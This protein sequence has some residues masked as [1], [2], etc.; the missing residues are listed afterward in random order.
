MIWLIRTEVCTMQNNIVKKVI[1]ASAGTGKTYRLSLEYLNLLIKYKASGIHFSEIVV[2]TFTNKA[3]AEIKEKIFEHL[4][5]IAD[6]NKDSGL[7]LK[8]NLQELFNIKVS[9]D[10]LNYLKLVYQQIKINQDKV[11]I[12]TIDSFINYT[13]KSMLAP[14]CMNLD[15][16]EISLTGDAYHLDDLYNL[17]FES[18]TMKD[19]FLGI[20]KKKD[21]KTL[22]FF[23]NFIISILNNR[24]LFELALKQ[25]KN[26]IFPENLIELYYESL[27]KNVSE[28]WD[29]VAD[30]Y[31]DL[32]FNTFSDLILTDF[33]D[34]IRVFLNLEKIN[35]L[36]DITSIKNEFYNILSSENFLLKNYKILLKNNFKF[37]NSQKFMKNK[38]LSFMENLQ[39]KFLEL[40][41]ILIQWLYVMLV[42][43]E[44]KELLELAEKIFSKYDE[45]KI[46]HKMLSHSDITFYTF[47]H[48]YDE[49][50]S[51]IDKQFNSVQNIF[52]EFLTYRIR[53]LLVDEFQDTSIMQYKILSP[54]ITELISGSTAKDYGGYIVVGDEKQ[55]IYGWRGGERELFRVLEQGLNPENLDV[56]YRS[57]KSI[58][59]FVNSVFRAENLKTFL[60]GNNADWECPLI[61]V[62][63]K[64]DDGFVKTIFFNSSNHDEDVY[65]VIA[66]KI[67]HPLAVTGRINTDNTVLLAY[68]N[69]QLSDLAEAIEEFTDIRFVKESSYT[70]VSHRAVKPLYSLLRFFIYNHI[71]DYL[72]FL[73]SD[74][75]LLDGTALKKIICLYE[76]Y[77]DEKMLNVF[78]KISIECPEIKILKIVDELYKIKDDDDPVVFV[79]KIIERLNITNIF[80]N[81]I[82]LKNINYFYSLVINFVIHNRESAHGLTSLVGFL[83]DE[84]ANQAFKQQS[85]NE[86]DVM[87]L[88]TIHKSKGLQF[89][90]VVVF[91]D[92]SGNRG[93]SRDSISFYYEFDCLYSDMKNFAVTYN[94]DDLFKKYY[95]LNSAENIASKHLKKELIEKLNSLYVAFTRAKKNLIVICDFKRKGKQ[96]PEIN[97]SSARTNDLM[98]IVALSS[99]DHYWVIYDQHF[100]ILKLV[101]E[102][103]PLKPETIAPV[104]KTQV[105]PSDFLSV[106]RSYLIKEKVNAQLLQLNYYTVFMEKKSI[107]LGDL[108]HYYL[109]FIKFNTEPE[110]EVAFKKT[111]SVY[112]SRLIR[113]ELIRILEITQK[114]INSMEWLFD[115]KWDKIFTEY[116]VFQEG[117]KYRL[118]RLMIDSKSG[119]IFIVDYKT[120]KAIDDEE[121]IAFYKTL[122]INI[123]QVR[124][125]D[126]NVKTKIIYLDK[127][128]SEFTSATTS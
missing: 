68:S 105:Q 102:T 108:I 82:D 80:S 10:D 92:L 69:K 39:D 20:I 71:S 117:R 18:E 12:S 53:F 24:W 64:K 112:G 78:S 16:Y 41:E 124:K 61:N 98:K 121:Q 86:L 90:T 119:E 17:I 67:I 34:S 32:N 44:E 96:L 43:P 31:S 72:D 79:K 118:D 5:H 6:V 9:Q 47:K 101:K 109:S 50:V 127:I 128:I 74:L 49:N 15:N 3:A 106:E 126:Y 37:W 70:V 22:D 75:V 46:K 87:Q 65:E 45:L 51:I 27:K 107:M 40:T 100:D 88:M 54:I 83:E 85:L 89:E 30:N 115:R 1:K 81:E 36:E 42:I 114:K 29:F 125:S 26:C 77:K 2:I 7:I 110:K 59:D 76:K 95:E 99:D 25:K 21:S 57:N 111:M 120:G 35:Q 63:N 62:Q 38:H 11:R 94:Y 91:L 73:R 33:N 19:K 8:Q 103:T 14:Y 52:Y 84:L 93:D 113:K 4:E 56:S 66:K 55:S 97:E 60:D 104:T 58:M 122:I 23:N 13:F 28:F 116:E 123:E 48:L